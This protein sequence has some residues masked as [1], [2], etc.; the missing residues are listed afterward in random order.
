MTS[1]NDNFQGDALGR[2]QATVDNFISQAK[3][4]NLSMELIIVEWNPPLDKPLLK[5]ALSLPDDL[6]PFSIRFIIVPPSIHKRYKCSKDISI[7]YGAAVSVGIR[8]ARGEFILTTNSH[9]L[10]SNELA[11]FLSLRKLEKD[12][13]YRVFRYDVH[14]DVIKCTS[15]EERLNFCEKNIIQTYPETKTS[16]HGLAEHPVL[17]TL[18]GGDFIL[19]SK[20]RWQL[21][22]GWPNL[23]N[24]AVGAD[25][26]LCYMAY[27]SGLKEEVLKDPMRLYHID[28]K[29]RW[30]PLS[31][32]S[33]VYLFVKNRIISK[34]DYNN[35][36][37]ILLR[38]IY[39]TVFKKEILGF[40][41]SA[42]YHI[43]RSLKRF[44]PAEMLDHNSRYLLWEYHKVLVEMLKGKRS[45]IYNDD[46]WG[47]PNENFKEYEKN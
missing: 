21:L 31:K 44:I 43:L 38:R 34:F 36:C 42:F 22:H 6:G 45:Y 7:V 1:R 13:F 27:L 35:K 20:E 2:L 41:A 8:R 11:H 29:N 17:Q 28:H 4:Y 5:D 23:N 26:L 19:F 14:R 15:L 25:G 3:Q 16:P 47:L 9:V 32:D 46:N 18:C 24:L 40:F 37:R 33:K 10:I 30:R 12:R 39:W